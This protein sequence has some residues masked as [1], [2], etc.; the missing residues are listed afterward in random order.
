MVH[1][2]AIGTGTN[3]IVG[4]SLDG[5]ITHGKGEVNMRIE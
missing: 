2:E 1:E 5:N 3:H 4:Y